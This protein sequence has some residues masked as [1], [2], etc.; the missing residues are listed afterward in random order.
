MSFHLLPVDAAKRTSAFKARCGIGRRAVHSSQFW[1]LLS[2]ECCTCAPLQEVV[3]WRAGPTGFYILEAREQQGSKQKT[4][5]FGS[6][7]T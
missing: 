4:C 7:R 6:R 3:A 5:C 1:A 2:L